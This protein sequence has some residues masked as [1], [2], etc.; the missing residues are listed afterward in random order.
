MPTSL[1]GAS[2][3]VPY[4]DRLGTG[5]TPFLF[6]VKQYISGIDGDN[7]AGILPGKSS[8]YNYHDHHHNHHHIVIMK[9][10]PHKPMLKINPPPHTALVSSLAGIPIFIASFVPDDGPYE[11][12]SSTPP[13]YIAE[14]KDVIVPNPVSGPGVILE[15][16]DTD[17]F[18]EATSLY[19]AHTFHSIISQPLIGTN[20]LCLREPIYFNQTFTNAVFR[21]G[22]VTL[23]SPGAAFPG[24]YGG[25]QGYSALGEN[26][27]YGPEQCSDSARLTDPKALA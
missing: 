10:I 18:T 14:V 19:T 21:N 25:V 26:V 7:V 15:A 23:Y 27:G 17:F 6:T 11:Q 13:E 22:S 24:V 16:I 5:K 1:L 12:I 4:V 20:G 9:G 8:A 3:Q 2:V